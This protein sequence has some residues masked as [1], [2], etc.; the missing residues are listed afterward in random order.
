MKNLG[1]LATAMLGG[2]ATSAPLLAA[3]E[4]DIY[5]QAVA[6]DDRLPGDYE[7][8]ADRKPAT[9]LAFFAIEPGDA[10]STCTRGAAITPSCLPTSSAPTARWL[11]TRTSPI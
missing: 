5:E 4:G 9:V 10:V 11:R 2:L 3:P 7:R 8:D 1:F 6:A